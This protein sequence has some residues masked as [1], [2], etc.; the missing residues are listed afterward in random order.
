M[1]DDSANRTAARGG[2]EPTIPDTEL[3]QSGAMSISSN[4]HSIRSVRSNQ[5]TLSFFRTLMGRRSTD[6]HGDATGLSGSIPRGVSSRFYMNAR[7]APQPPDTTTNMER[8]NYNGED[9][10]P[11]GEEEYRPSCWQSFCQWLTVPSY[12]RKHY[13]KLVMD[14]RLWRGTLVLFTIALIFGAQM[15]DLFCPRQADF[16]FDIL[17]LTMFGFFLVDIIMRM[18]V[19]PNYFVFQAFGRGE[20]SLDNSCSCL[21]IQVG[22]FIFWCELIATLTLLFEISFISDTEFGIKTVDIKL[23]SF[24]A[25]VRTH[26]RTH[27]RLP[28]ITVTEQQISD[29]S[30]SAYFPFSDRVTA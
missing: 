9:V 12:V 7:S 6:Y 25:P 21:D 2:E 11:P 30:F 20:V 24:G 4:S 3:R 29:T 10:P 16:V 26:A 17:F 28:T 23:N 19:E 8:A 27:A 5:K 15:R 22:S 18:D 13:F 14:S 1:D